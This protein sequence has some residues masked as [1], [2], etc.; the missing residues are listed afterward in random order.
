MFSFLSICLFFQFLRHSFHFFFFSLDQFV[1]LGTFGP[2]W[3]ASWDQNLLSGSLLKQNFNVTD[4]VCVQVRFGARSVKL[5]AGT[6]TLAATTFLQCQRSHEWRGRAVVLGVCSALS[7][8]NRSQILVGETLPGGLTS[9]CGEA[10]RGSLVTRTEFSLR[11]GISRLRNFKFG[12]FCESPT[13]FDQ[14]LSFC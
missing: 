7:A 10:T 5:S 8:L 1:H 13:C 11:Y 6:Q 14:G 4:C 9:A 12:L 3:S 2:I